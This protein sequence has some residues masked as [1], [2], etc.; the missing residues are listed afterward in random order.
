MLNLE[1]GRAYLALPQGEGTAGG[2]GAGVLLLHAWWGLNDFFIKLA[3]RLASEGFVVLAPDMFDGEIASTIEEAET[4]VGTKNDENRII[5]L[6]DEALDYLKNLPQVTSTDLG[7]IGVSFGAAWG[8]VMAD[9]RPDVVG[10]MVLFY[11][12]YNNDWKN[13]RAAFQGHYAENDPFEPREAVEELEKNLTDLKR[14]ANFFVY[15]GTEHWFFEPDRP[16]YHPES[17]RVAY[18]ATVKFLKEKLPTT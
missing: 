12:V 10:A 7:L 6:V 3:D 1:H 5:P 14:E 17:A 9:R 18:E 16:Q 15:S 4:L 2:T 11:G 13:I 8:L